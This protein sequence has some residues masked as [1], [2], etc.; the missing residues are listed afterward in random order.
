MRSE[1][2]AATL[3]TGC[4]LFSFVL[5][6]YPA[7]LRQQFGPDMEDVFGQQ[8]R[9]EYAQKGLLGVLRVWIGVVSDVLLSSASV[10]IDWRAVVVRGV[11]LVGSFVLFALFFA[12]SHLAARCI[13]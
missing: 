12:A 4:R 5:P 6:L 7:S 9:G 11:S 13:K 2:R 10:Q 1:I 8:I 3:T